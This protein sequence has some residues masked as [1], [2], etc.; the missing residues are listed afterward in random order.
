MIANGSPA[1]TGFG[2]P[3]FTVSTLQAMWQSNQSLEAQL[4]LDPL[5]AACRASPSAKAS[6]GTT[7]DLT[8][9]CDGPRRL[10]QDRQSRRGRRLALLG[11]GRLRPEHSDFWSDTLRADRAA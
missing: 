5:V 8:A 10:R 1:P 7:V 3:K 9:A 6:N 11:M 4:V 2:P